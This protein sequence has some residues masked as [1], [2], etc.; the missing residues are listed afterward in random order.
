MQ[1]DYFLFPELTYNTDLRV[2]NGINFTRREVDIIAC[3]VRGVT[4]TKKIAEFLSRTKG[5]E[6]EGDGIE[7]HIANIKRKIKSN[8]NNI[9]DGSNRASIAFFFTQ[10]DKY[11][12]LDR[13]YLALAIEREFNLSLLYI[14]NYL[15]ID[16]REHWTIFKLS[17]ETG[18]TN[19][20][21][22]SNDTT[23]GV[24]FIA[25]FLNKNL[26]LLTSNASVKSTRSFELL[27]SRFLDKPKQYCIED[28]NVNIICTIQKSIAQPE[29]EI[30]KA[31]I[32]NEEKNKVILLILE[33]NNAVLIQA[34]ASNPNLKCIS[35]S[36][37][38]NYY[39]LFFEILKLI[40]PSA[41]DKIEVVQQ[42]FNKRC[43]DELNFDS[44]HQPI[45][46][47]EDRS[48]CS[49]NTNYISNNI[50][51]NNKS[52]SKHGDSGGDNG[53]IDNGLVQ[54]L[55]YI[56]KLKRYK[57]V[58]LLFLFLAAVGAFIYDYNRNDICNELLPKFFEDLSIRNLT[59]KESEKNDK[60]IKQ[61]DLIVKQITSGKIKKYFNHTTLKP[62]ELV[63]CIYNLNAIAS[64][65]LFKEHDAVKA[66]KVLKYAKNLA[67]SYVIS[68]GSQ[69]KLKPDFNKS[70]PEEVY[71]ELNITTSDLPHMYA[72]TMYFLGRSAVYQQDI[73]SAERYFKLSRY[74][75]QK[76]GLFTEILSMLSL[77]IIKGDK[78]ELAIKNKNYS[79][80]QKLLTEVINEYGSLKENDMEYKKDY[81]PNNYNPTTIIPKQD[82]YHLIE[83]TKRM[84]GLY[85]K[86]I[87]VTDDKVKQVK[88]LEAGTKQL[89]GTN[90]GQQGVL[91]IL[92]NAD[93]LGVSAKIV[94]DSYNTIG[95]FLLTLHDKTIDFVQLRETIIRR[96]NLVKEYDAIMDGIDQDNNVNNDSK[97]TTINDL[98]A[99]ELIFRK[100]KSLGRNNEFCKADSYDGLMK[101]YE[102]LINSPNIAEKD[103][104]LLSAKIQE[105]K[106]ARDEINQELK[107]RK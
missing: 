47:N 42:N 26:K 85:K 81:R 69:G 64:F 49:S 45:F 63:N 30:L 92:T 79:L 59:I 83:C 66:E 91:D 76:L 7:A 3:F 62:A 53:I 65:A 98:K 46:T 75:G 24:D 84:I 95:Y 67:E 31:P 99:I 35:T 16:T 25:T 102:R 104:D 40:F 38:E 97:Q 100:A 60:I 107:R 54:K 103:S 32:L 20:N 18:K 5:R 44:T 41:K 14:I 17:E 56:N 4:I 61:F 28:V 58:T 22:H 71:R 12:S 33:S 87:E 74:L 68:K 82:V 88:Y 90:A 73:E 34:L 96:L 23:S 6:L 94:A 78:A 77:N 93:N 89:A 13:H 9:L 55:P 105:Y 43:V 72:T 8:N 19:N 48:E 52:D 1:N 101:T 2:I 21:D 10:S 36:D 15:D 80:A 39:L 37:S 106:K 70:T 11:L 51:K 57:F 86:L 29:S 50:V 27:Y